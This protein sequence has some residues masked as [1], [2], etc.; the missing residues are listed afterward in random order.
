MDNFFTQRTCDRCGG[1]LEGGRTMSMFNN[2][3]ICMKCK[4]E[5]TKRTDYK[6]AQEADISAIRNGNYNFK[7]IGLNTQE[8]KEQ[9]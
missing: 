4:E 8:R 9:K 3:C 2:D 7:G 5:E 6:D 1:S